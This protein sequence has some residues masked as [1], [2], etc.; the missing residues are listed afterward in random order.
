MKE[1]K[2]LNANNIISTRKR[3][4]SEI[5]TYWSFIKAENTLRNNA[6]K[7]RTHN[8]QE[9]YNQ[10]TQKIEHRI[11]IKGLLNNLNNDKLSFNSTEFKKTHY[12]NIFRLQECQEQIT[13]LNEI[14]KRCLAP[15]LKAQKG[16]KALGYNEV[17]TH[18][19]ISS[20]INKLELM[21]ASCKSA[22][23]KYNDETQIEIIDNS[24]DAVLAA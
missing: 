21:V 19:K 14:R 11:L 2:K 20:I 24:L 9:L 16:K 7:F 6:L 10:I 22:I 3:L 8:L 18:E 17:F 4:D 12:Y 13:K 23:A 1:N 15:Q 5:A